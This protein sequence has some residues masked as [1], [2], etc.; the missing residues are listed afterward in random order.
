MAKL[1]LRGWTNLLMRWPMPYAS[2]VATAGVRAFRRGQGQARGSRACGDGGVVGLGHAQRVS[3]R[4]A[5]P[6]AGRRPAV[7]FGLER[8]RRRQVAATGRLS[9]LTAHDRAGTAT[10]TTSRT[11]MST[12]TLV[13]CSTYANEIGRAHV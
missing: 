12:S 5:D 4:G 3:G 9:G 8:G 13:R 10:S 11:R 2:S 6:F 1:R 7:R